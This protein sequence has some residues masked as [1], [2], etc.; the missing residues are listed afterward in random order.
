M[1]V[2]IIQS[3]QQLAAL[4]PF[5]TEDYIDNKWIHICK[6]HHGD[7]NCSEHSQLLQSGQ[8]PTLSI[9][10]IPDF[11]AQSIRIILNQLI[12]HFQYDDDNDEDDDNNNLD[13][14]MMCPGC[15]LPFPE[16]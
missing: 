12:E 3:I 8:L 5:L 14:M 1:P 4:I 11:L 16:Q 10:Y 2:Y 15:G 13:A 6:L 7:I 9:V